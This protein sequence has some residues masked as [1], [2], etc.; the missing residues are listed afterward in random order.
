MVEIGIADR[1]TTFTASDFGRTLSSNGRGSDHAW[2][3]NMMVMG[4][5]V[6]GGDIYGSY[7]SLALGGPVDTGRGR[8]IPTLSVDEYFAD[9]ALWFGVPAADLDQVLPNI[10]RFYT[11]GGA[12]PIGMMAAATAGNGSGGVGGGVGGT[13]GRFGRRPETSPSDEGTPEQKSRRRML[14][15]R[16]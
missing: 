10:R 16:S 4:G 7:P 3:G 11:P 15:R 9:L 6:Q 1:V 5:A 2:G 12:P 8:L 14:R 13:G